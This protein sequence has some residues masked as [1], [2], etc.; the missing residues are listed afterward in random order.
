MHRKLFRAFF[1]SGLGLL[2]CLNIPA[3]AQDASLPD[4]PGKDKVVTACNGCHNLG[5]ATNQHLSANRWADIVSVMVEYG[6]P[7]ADS[8]FNTVVKYLAANFGPEPTTGQGAR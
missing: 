5:E 8:D 2:I 1:P 6:A 4:G 3:A 7:V